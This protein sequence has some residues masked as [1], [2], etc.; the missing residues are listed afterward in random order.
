MRSPAA[1][2]SSKFRPS[3][4]ENSVHP[5]REAPAHCSVV[6]GIMTLSCL[7]SAVALSMVV[8]GTTPV[9]IEMVEGARSSGI[10]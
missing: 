6:T 9:D 2:V 4:H 10:R 5:G 1:A 3:C 7:H 8:R